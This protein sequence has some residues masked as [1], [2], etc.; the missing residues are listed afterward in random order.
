MRIEKG[1]DWERVRDLEREVKSCKEKRIR[2]EEA[3]KKQKSE[4]QEFRRLAALSIRTLVYY[5][6]WSS[7]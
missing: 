5:V 3:E 6:P 4:E 1:R 2:T 7:A